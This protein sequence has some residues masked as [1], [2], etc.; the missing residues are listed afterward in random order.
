MNISIL[1]GAGL[2]GVGDGTLANG[3][4]PPNPVGAC[5]NKRD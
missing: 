3:F 2:A 5:E 4:G 1:P